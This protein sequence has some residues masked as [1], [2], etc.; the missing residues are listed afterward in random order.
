MDTFATKQKRE[1]ASHP[2]NFLTQSYKTYPFF[3]HLNTNPVFFSLNSQAYYRS[4][5]FLLFYN[6]FSFHRIDPTDFF[7]FQFRSREIC[8][9]HRSPILSH[10]RQGEPE[11]LS[12][13]LPLGREVRR[14]HQSMERRIAKRR[15]PGLKSY[16]N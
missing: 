5:N 12:R 1:V 16:C 14:V 7:P 6:I 13:L 15:L 11:H 9:Q 2:Q 10:L 3:R 4:I 8:S